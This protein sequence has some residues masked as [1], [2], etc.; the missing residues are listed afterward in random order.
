MRP[1]ILATAL[2]LA[3]G[4]NVMHKPNFSSVQQVRGCRTNDA[5]IRSCEARGGQNCASVCPMI[6]R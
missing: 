1:I 6:C 3:F 5:C 4:A 2:P